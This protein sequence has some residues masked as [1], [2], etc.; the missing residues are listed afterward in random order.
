M[1]FLAHWFVSPWWWRHY[2]LP[3]HRFL[4]EP[5]GVTS[6]RTEFFRKR[7]VFW[8]ITLCSQLKVSGD[9]IETYS[10]DYHGNMLPHLHGLRVSRVRNQ[11]RQ[12]KLAVRTKNPINFRDKWKSQSCWVSPVCPSSRILN[13]RKKVSESG[14]VSVLRWG[15]TLLC[16]VS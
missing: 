1:L 2:V 16:W 12:A 11:Q 14:S 15:E 4:Q 8:D 13:T 6:Q 7:P 10:L 9:S 3:K 5:H